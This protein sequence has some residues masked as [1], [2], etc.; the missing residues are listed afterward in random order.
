[1][2]RHEVNKLRN[3]RFQREK[4]KEHQQAKMA[5]PHGSILTLWEDLRRVNAGVD[6][7]GKSRNAEGSG[8]VVPA[9]DQKHT[10]IAEILR[11]IVGD[12]PYASAPELST[13]GSTEAPPL[14]GATLAQAACRADLSRVL[15]SCAKFG[16]HTDRNCI[17]RHLS[18]HLPHL[19]CNP[20]AAPLLSALSRHSR[21]PLNIAMAR[22]LIPHAHDML[23]HRVAFHVLDTVYHNTPGFVRAALDAA[24]IA[25]DLALRKE[26]L[27]SFRTGLALIPEFTAPTTG[28][29]AV[30]AGDGD[31]TVEVVDRDGDDAGDIAK[32]KGKKGA[33]GAAAQQQQAPE[34]T[35]GRGGRVVGGAVSAAAGFAGNVRNVPSFDLQ[36]RL[37]ADTA[38]RRRVMR[39]LADVMDKVVTKGAS[40]NSEYVQRA[41]ETYLRFAHLS[42]AVE[43]A[44]E[45]VKHVVT[46]MNTRGGAMIALHCINYTGT[47]GWFSMLRSLKKSLR[48]VLRGETS[49]LVLC[50]LIDVLPLESAKVAQRRAGD[51]LA[52]A[53]DSEADD[54]GD[55]GKESAAD[56]V[57]RIAAQVGVRT[58]VEAL[59]VPEVLRDVR[60]ARDVLLENPTGAK[61]VL[62]LLTRQ[63]YRKHRYFT[64]AHAR[65]LW[66]EAE[67]GESET[68]WASVGGILGDDEDKDGDEIVEIDVCS[69]DPSPA[70][71]HTAVLDAI[72][73][74]LKAIIL[75]DCVSVQRS[76]L[77]STAGGRGGHERNPA[78]AK[79]RA[80]RG[81]DEGGNV[82][83]PLSLARVFTAKRVMSELLYQARG[84]APHPVLC[85]PAFVEI[86]AA[87][88]SVDVARAEPIAEGD[89]K[90]AKRAR[91]A[92]ES[93]DDEA[94]EAADD[95]AMVAA[96]KKGAAAKPV[97]ASAKPAKGTTAA[98]RAAAPKTDKPAAKAAA[99]AAAPKAPPA[100]R[101]AGAGKPAA[102]VAAKTGAAA[103]PVAAKAPGA[104]AAKP[105]PAA[106]KP[107]AVAAKP[108]TKPSAAAKPAAPVAKPAGPKAVPAKPAAAV[109]PAVKP[110]SKPAAVAAKPAAAAK[111]PAAKGKAK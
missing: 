48:D 12:D 103:K 106:A 111:R 36:G 95:V 90:P 4:R 42:N 7:S 107:A 93:S 58:F 30:A 105:A 5:S 65:L 91:T 74:V 2:V 23:P 3:V 51:L 87:A 8:V 66:H 50:R 18:A 25:K 57:E 56:R 101:V 13:R 104:A 46:I 63:L 39:P 79:R 77:R 76:Q 102:A 73:P 24:A 16:R 34:M 35:T 47:V 60:V 9:R 53:S 109:K 70:E 86:L 71:K 31:G 68:A 67:K 96:G 29:E 75:A 28:D 59:L 85:D 22:L 100:K 55:K 78:A 83:V 49:V 20:Y 43:V 44:N 64:P 38:L 45:L 61:F 41:V 33:K 37:S 26:V 110:A 88:M 69:A 19:A 98:T 72:L 11:L 94:E 14:R 89:A 108:A 40:M 54:E 81:E 84:E 92:E 82:R 99:V 6:I 62:H 97:A 17:L 10:L 15:Q 80:D 1:M 32:P 52:D 21:S 27:D